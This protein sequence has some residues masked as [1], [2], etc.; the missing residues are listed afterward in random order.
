MATV[1]LGASPSDL[2]VVSSPTRSLPDTDERSCRNWEL[3]NFAGNLKSAM[4]TYS[5]CKFMKGR[6]DGEFCGGVANTFRKL[7]LSRKLGREPAKST[8]ATTTAVARDK[9]K[10]AKLAIG[11]LADDLLRAI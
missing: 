11:L 6:A 9:K 2:A 10:G 5:L 4:S 1:Y 3:A 7:R 8:S